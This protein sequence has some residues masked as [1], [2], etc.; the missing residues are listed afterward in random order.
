MP[1]RLAPESLAEPAVTPALTLLPAPRTLRRLAPRFWFRSEVS[2]DE[3]VSATAPEAPD[4]A[5]IPLLRVA[6]MMMRRTLGTL[7]R[8]LLTLRF[9]LRLLQV[10][11]ALTLAFGV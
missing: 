8:P 7:L 11:P 3:P 5:S 1:R 6:R 9:H 10:R 4:A 2:A